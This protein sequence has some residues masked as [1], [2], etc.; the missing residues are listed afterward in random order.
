MYFSARW[1]VRDDPQNRD[2]R[3]LTEVES[4]FGILR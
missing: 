3:V 1:I 2:T 4:G